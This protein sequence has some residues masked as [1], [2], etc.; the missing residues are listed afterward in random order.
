MRHHW[1]VKNAKT[2][3]NISSSSTN[4]TFNQTATSTSSASNASAYYTPN[5]SISSQS[6]ATIATKPATASGPTPVV[7]SNYAANT[8]TPTATTSTT[9]SSLIK[10]ASINSASSGIIPNHGNIHAKSTTATTTPAANPVKYYNS[11]H[12]SNLRTNLHSAASS[13]H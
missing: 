12:S 5:S 6:N 10:S 3:L 11:T 1:I 8:T 4:S 13:K 9:S 7:E 2:D